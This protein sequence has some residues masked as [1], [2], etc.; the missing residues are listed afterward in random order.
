M[1][2]KV[3]GLWGDSITYGANDTEALGWAGRL[4]KSFPVESDVDVYNFGVCGDT[5]DDI[6]KRFVIEA[7]SIKPNIVV[8][9]VGINDAKY[10]LNESMNKVPLERY[11]ENMRELIKAAKDYTNTIYVVSATKADEAYMR[12]SGTRFVNDVIKTY[13]DFLQD[14]STS[15]GLTFINVFDTLD[16]RTDLADGLHP[17]AQGYTKMFDVIREVVK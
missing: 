10:P 16:I 11:K 9:A 7:N 13:N 6:L 4:R 3:I 17:N 14:L 1:T 2:D 12:K 8:F 15:E 5:T